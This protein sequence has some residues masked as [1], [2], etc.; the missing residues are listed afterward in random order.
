VIPPWDR[1]A[2]LASPRFAAVHDL[3]AELPADRAP[4]RDDFNRLAERRALAN[5]RGIPIRF[6][7]PAAG[8]DYEARIDRAGE[9]PT[10]DASWHDCFNALAWLA[11]PAT[12]ATINRLHAAH[13]IAGAR[14]T[15]RDVLTLFDEDGMAMATADASLAEHLRAFRWRALFVERRAEVLRSVR[16]LGVGHALHEKLLAPFRGLTAKVLVVEADRA[17]LDAPR[18]LRARVDRALAAALDAPAAL[19][20]TRALAPLPVQG[21]PGWWAANEDPAFYEDTG[22]FRPGRRK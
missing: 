19:V 4:V 2:L 6:V 22:Q 7:A 14:G 15:P 12:K 1:G 3:L 10:R 18:E 5:W 8:A 21:I 11:F 9:V 20:S 17:V 16:F 13:R